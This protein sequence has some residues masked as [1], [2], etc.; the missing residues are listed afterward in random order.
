LRLRAASTLVAAMMEHSASEG[1][2]E[3]ALRTL[4]NLTVNNAGM[5][6]VPY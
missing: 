3:Q 4:I 2:Q 5:D 1:V 6:Q